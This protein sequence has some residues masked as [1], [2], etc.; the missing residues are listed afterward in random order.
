MR[1][2]PAPQV[3]LVSQAAI[4]LPPE[5]GTNLVG[6]ANVELPIVT[7]QGTTPAAAPTTT[8]KDGPST[9]AQAKSLLKG[10][11]GAPAGL[12]GSG[13][14]FGEKVDIPA[15]SKPV[16]ADAAPTG[17][18]RRLLEGPAAAPPIEIAAIALQEAKTLDIPEKLDDDFDYVVLL[19]T[20]LQ[21]AL[22]AVSLASQPTLELI[23]VL[24]LIVVDAPVIER[25]L[26][27]RRGPPLA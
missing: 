27:Y 25:P 24:P 6:S 12:K 22:P 3:D 19:V 10:M 9:A 14:S 16:V 18:D 26:P 23:G 17:I 7:G 4:D 1:P 5:S 2:T 8:A 20:S 11:V 13:F 15:P 21:A